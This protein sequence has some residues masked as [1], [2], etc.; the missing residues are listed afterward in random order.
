MCHKCRI[1][2]N[3]LYEDER[4]IV[5]TKIP[6]RKKSRNEPKVNNKIAVVFYCRSQVTR[7]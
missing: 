5:T 4:E 3:L 6:E 1:S 2:K 7:I